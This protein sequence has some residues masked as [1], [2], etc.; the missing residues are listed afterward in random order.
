MLLLALVTGQ[1]RGDLAKM[2]FDDVVTDDQSRQ[3]LRVEQQKE[4]GK[5]YGARVEIPLSLRLDA[6]GMTLGDVIEHCRGSAKP[7]PTL[8]RKAGGGP[9]EDSSL[10]A[11]F[12]EHIVAVL[13]DHAHPKHVWPSLHE[14]RSLAAR[15]YKAQGLNPQI[16]LGHKAAEMTEVYTDDRGLSSK[17]WKRVELHASAS[18]QVEFPNV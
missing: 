12:H 11:R 2:R 10:S 9:M 17:E 8:L 16:L 3:F 1:R 18:S 13:G 4:S 7:G 5:G 14:C 15:L 6:I